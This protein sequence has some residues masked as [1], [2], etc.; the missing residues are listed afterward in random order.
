V[1]ELERTSTKD[2][3]D[4]DSILQR[5]NHMKNK[6]QSYRTSMHKEDAD[7]QKLAQEIAQMKDMM[8]SYKTSM[9]KEDAD[10]QKVAK[11]ITDEFQQIEQ[12]RA[13]TKAKADRTNTEQSKSGEKE[14]VTTKPSAELERTF[15][16]D[17]E[18][19]DASASLEEPKEHEDYESFPRKSASAPEASQPDEADIAADQDAFLSQIYGPEEQQELAELEQQELAGLSKEDSEDLTEGEEKRNDSWN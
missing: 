16:K 9:H 1:A 10:N 7:N 14:D 6:M 11:E 18:H 15:S 5:I 13:I 8:H 19:E 4:Q 2:D 3:E 12:T 17:D